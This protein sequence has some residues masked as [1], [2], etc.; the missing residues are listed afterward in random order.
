MKNFRLLFLIVILIGAAVAFTQ[1]PT[2]LGLDL[3]G[4]T[5]LVL[6]AKDTPDQPVDSDTVIGVMSVIRNRV[7]GLGVTEPVLQRKGLRQ[8]VVE[9]PGVKDPERA[10]KL[11]G[12]TALLEFVAADWAPENL[13]SL[14]KEKQEIL[15]GKNVKVASM[16]ITDA[17]GKVVATRTL[18]LHRTELTGSDLKYANPGTDELG[19]PVVSIAFKKEGTKRFADLTRSNMGKPIAIV[20][21]GKV[22]SAPNVRAVINNGQAVIEGGFSVQ[23][24]RD[25]VIKLKAGSLPV[26]VE[27]VSNRIVGPTL[28][29]DSIAKSKVAGM[30]GLLIVSLYMVVFYRVG[31]FVANLALCAYLLIV[32]ALLKV[33]DATLTLPGIA[34]VI[35]T[36]GMAVDANVIIFERIK[37]EISLGET[38]LGAIN[39]GYSKAFVAILDSNITTMIAAVVLFWLGTGTI[40]GFAVTLS[41]GIVVSMFSAIFVTKLLLTGVARM[42]GMTAQW[43]F[44]GVKS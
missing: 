21:D 2:R 29:R 18:I 30:I 3:Q 20:L 5:R 31:G 39:S 42:R 23:E 41:I 27:I 8:I 32:M 16:P 40:K 6:E 17:S 22:V 19:N 25:L 44:G 38:V 11:I 33:F 24:M 4:G 1:I 36:L 7:N 37:E 14:S 12:E 26:P 35:L 43:L 10:I 15:V 34:G 13:A 9:L 28:G